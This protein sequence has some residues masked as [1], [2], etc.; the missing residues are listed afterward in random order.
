MCPGSH[1]CSHLVAR[2]QRTISTQW[3]WRRVH[4]IS[5]TCSHSAARTTSAW[6]GFPPSRTTASDC[7]LWPVSPPH[8]TALRQTSACVGSRSRARMPSSAQRAPATTPTICV[9]PPSA[10]QRMIC[11]CSPRCRPPC[12]THAVCGAVPGDRARVAADAFH[13]RRRRRH[14]RLRQ[15]RRQRCRSSMTLAAPLTVVR[16]RAM[17]DRCGGGTQTPNCTCI[18]YD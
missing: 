9:R 1:R 7:W 6:V 10:S 2:H 18:C 8:T 16:T 4:P 15:R 5:S 12:L 11:G 17:F 3:R 14:S 13:R